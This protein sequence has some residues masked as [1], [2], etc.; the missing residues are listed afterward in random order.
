MLNVLE[1]NFALEFRKN[2]YSMTYSNSFA[3]HDFNER[4][5]VQLTRG[6]NERNWKV[7]CTNLLVFVFV[8][9][10]SSMFVCTGR[11]SDSKMDRAEEQWESFSFG[12]FWTNR[13]EI[14]D[15]W[16]IVLLEI[17]RKFLLNHWSNHFRRLIGMK[18]FSRI[19]SPKFSSDDLIC[20]DIYTEESW[21]D[22]ISHP[23]E[24]CPWSYS[25]SLRLIRGKSLLKFHWKHSKDMSTRFFEVSQLNELI[26]T[27]KMRGICF[28]L[29]V[30]DDDL[31]RRRRPD[32]A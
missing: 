2:L 13:V 18:N 29:F 10:I 22:Q 9:F 7:H 12:R 20:N 30:D 17:K 1:K 5:E 25:L 27:R 26:S 32:S 19:N 11:N 4:D 23:F 28:L 16:R 24:V 3:R 14:F 31:H 15:R 21:A 8:L 6:K